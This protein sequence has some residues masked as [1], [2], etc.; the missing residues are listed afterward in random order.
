VNQILHAS[1]NARP[2]EYIDIFLRWEMTEQAYKDTCRDFRRRYG[3]GAPVTAALLAAWYDGEALNHRR[4]MMRTYEIQVEIVVAD[5]IAAGGTVYIEELDLTVC[6]N[7]ADRRE[8]EHPFSPS[9]RVRRG[10]ASEIPHMGEE[11]FVM[12]IRAIDNSSLKSRHDR[13]L[14]I[15]DLVYH[16]PIERDHMCD[17]G[18]YITT[19]YDADTKNATGR[20]QRVVT[21]RMGFDE[22]DKLF[23]MYDTIEQAREGLTTEE[24]RKEEIL[25]R[26]YEQ[27]IADLERQN[28]K[29]ERD[30]AHWRE[31]STH[32][33]QS[34]REKEERN[35][36]R[37][38]EEN[39][40][41]QTRSF[42]EWMKLVGGFMTALVGIAAT[43]AKLKPT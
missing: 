38:S 11:T 3:S 2:P 5:V 35:Q 19:R 4:D 12:S 6:V 22:A 15:G 41:E 29:L 43:V 34:S 33:Q 17:N 32:E 27:K 26:Q 16:V 23:Q 39:V 37:N 20:T 31:R 28:E 21:R 9:N 7:G 40:R 18:V 42:T 36:K 13:F 14:K 8:E 1:K 24:L 10:L 30:H 25:R